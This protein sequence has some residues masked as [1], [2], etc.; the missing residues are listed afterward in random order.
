MHDLGF[1]SAPATNRLNHLARLQDSPEKALGSNSTL[2]LIGPFSCAPLIKGL[3]AIL[4][5]LLL[6]SRLAVVIVARPYVSMVVWIEACLINSRCKEMGASLASSHAREYSLTRGWMLALDV[7]YRH[8]G[9]TRVN[10]YTHSGS[11]QRAESGWTPAPAT[12]SASHRRSNTVGKPT[13][14]CSSAPA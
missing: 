13:W 8:S 12:G 3:S 4:A 5:T 2:A 7:T 11:Q 6:N 1:K 14:A 9:N 10:G